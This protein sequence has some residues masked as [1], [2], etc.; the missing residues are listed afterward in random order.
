M[1]NDWMIFS[2]FWRWR[3]LGQSIMSCIWKLLIREVVSGGTVLIR[4][5]VSG[6]TVGM[7]NVLVYYFHF[8][9]KLLEISVMN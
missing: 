5:V 2:L 1:P 6:G 3:G 7:K 9:T 8:W 4:E